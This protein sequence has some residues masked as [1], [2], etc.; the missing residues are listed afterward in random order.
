MAS[1]PWQGGDME[2]SVQTPVSATMPWLAASVILLG[3]TALAG[4]AAFGLSHVSQVPGW[5]AGV[6]GGS[7]GALLSA[8]GFLALWGQAQAT[9]TA[10]IGRVEQRIADTALSLGGLKG[11]VVELEDKVKSEAEPQDAAVTA[12]LKVLQQLLAQVV[13]RR[14]DSDMTDSPTARIEPELDIPGRRAEAETLDIMRAAL[15]DSRV[16]LYLQPIVRLP[17]RRVAHYEAVSRVRD[18]AGD[19]I[20]PGDYLRPAEAAGLSGTL[21]NLLLF[22]C[23]SLVRQLGPR[24][25][26]MRIFVNLAPA[27]LR[28]PAFLREFVGFMKQNRDLAQ[29]LVFEVAADDMAHLGPHVH[30]ELAALARQGFAFSIDR[31]TSLDFDSFQLAAWNVQFVKVDA[32]L[33]LTE[34]A[35]GY[36]RDDVKALLAR[37]NI[38]LI[39]TRI[40]TEKTVLEV[41]D[42]RIDYGQGYL[43]GAPRPARADLATGK[44]A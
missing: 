31:V 23:I 32:D 34:E 16:D 7:I 18:A 36:H 5:L 28:D 24:K 26:G 30:D 22:R 20:F 21:D 19:V 42:E 4:A 29:R 10:R 25:P 39:A 15:E 40:E 33:L 3:S 11:S 12:E 38:E 27:S 14:A 37:Q 17:S 41:L 8:G 44:A 13:T 6:A 9:M 2:D 35:I 43:F 1:G